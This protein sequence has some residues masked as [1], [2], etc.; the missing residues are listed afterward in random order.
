MPGQRAG[1]TR[2]RVLA[3]AR[4]LVAEEGLQALTMRNL[5]ARL[6]VRP[7]AL[8]SHVPNKGALLDELLDDVLAEVDAPSQDAD[9]PAAA[10]HALMGST[11]DVLLAHPDLVPLYLAR[12]GTRGPNARRLGDVMDT[13]LARAGVKGARVH[14]ARR[15][16]I[17]YTLG[18]A[19][20]AT[21]PSF[22]PDGVR[23]LSA[24]EL[25]DN[26]DSGLRWLLAG[27]GR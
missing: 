9:D 11:Y 20:F 27:I 17:V 24:D 25:R 2:G 7:N 1:L 21:R 10:V 13:L 23:V 4:E 14:E 19:A 16:L 12:Q 3:A 5:A 6:V 26:F 8:Y 15:A 18:F 22:E